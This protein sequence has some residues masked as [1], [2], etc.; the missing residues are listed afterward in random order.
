MKMNKLLIV[1]F[2]IS[3][4]PSHARAQT[5]PQKSVC[6]EL[7]QVQNEIK[8]L[9]RNRTLWQ[10]AIDEFTTEKTLNEDGTKRKMDA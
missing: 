7:C 4:V 1:F 3:I 6:D 10:G 2:I 8:K 5:V 9:E